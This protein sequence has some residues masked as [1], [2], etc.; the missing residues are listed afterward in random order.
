MIKHC[1]EGGTKDAPTLIQD[2][3]IRLLAVRVFG[4]LRLRSECHVDFVLCD[5][6]EHHNRLQPRA[7]RLR[8]DAPLVGAWSRPSV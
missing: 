6:A 3:E 4:R 2:Y 7:A 8:V 1:Q 5:C